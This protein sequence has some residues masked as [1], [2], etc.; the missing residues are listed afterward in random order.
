MRIRKCIAILLA[1]LMAVGMSAVA[2]ADQ[3]G[4]VLF[5]LLQID[6]E[7]VCLALVLENAEGL[8][9]MDLTIRYDPEVLAFANGSDER[10]YYAEDALAGRQKL[11]DYFVHNYNETEPGTVLYAAYF[12]N[13]LD[14]DP[15][16]AT[17]L[18][19]EILDPAVSSTEIVIET[20]NGTMLKCYPLVLTLAGGETD[21]ELSSLAMLYSNSISPE[22]VSL[23][24]L[25]DHAEGLKSFDL[26]ISY[27]P[28]V[29]AFDYD[30]DPSHYYGLHAAE[31]L[32]ED[33]R[34]YSHEINGNEAGIVRYG[35]FFYESLDCNWFAAANL[36][37]DV[38]DPAVESTSIEIAVL[39]NSGV[40]L[41]GLPFEFVICEP[42]DEVQPLAL[43][44]QTAYT[45]DSAQFE[46]VLADA[47]GLTAFD[48][49]ITYDPEVLAFANGDDETAYY[50]EDAAAGREGDEYFYTH[51]F[52]GTEAG[53]VKYGGYFFDPLEENW[54]SAAILDFDVLDNAC[55]STEIG[56][57]LT[58]AA[59][60]ELAALSF[61]L[62]LGDPTVGD[63]DPAVMLMDE[64]VDS[65][66]WVRMS[67]LFAGAQ[68]LESLDLEISYDPEV[69]SFDN[70][71]DDAEEYYGMDAFTRRLADPDFYTH[72][73][74]LQEPGLVKYAGFFYDSLDMGWFHAA[75]FD[76]DVLNPNAGATEITVTVT[77]ATGVAPVSFDYVLMLGEPVP[78]VVTAETIGDIDGDG[79]VTAGDARTAL[80]V[81]VGLEGIR[82]D[83]WVIADVDF[84][85]QITAADARLILRAA[86]GL[87]DREEWVK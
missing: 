7:S 70:E 15:F 74:T 39:N 76:F 40:E 77:N 32:A 66:E 6:D 14:M 8:T 72:A 86:V 52:N 54:F 73:F 12:H 64:L 4:E 27:D 49:D 10:Q 43:L 42:E 48:L 56:M 84:D 5:D 3:P 85:D 63:A 17:I 16:H 25:L 53:L 75:Y 61:T 55:G 38:L 62:V 19:F 65:D 68:G 57:T 30:G 79:K 50:G 60:T 33:P 20:R 23:S 28:E 13:S 22:H 46:L 59:G 80:R 87:E 58:N 9:G 51:S 34:F 29:L 36:E 69:L 35:A 44:G 37:F 41:A 18:D 24:L 47:M 78:S 67:L 82:E 2:F 31:R 1:A 21:P 45:G 81:A 11:A 83:L 26:V 71:E